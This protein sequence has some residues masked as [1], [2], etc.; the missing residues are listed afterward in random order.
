MLS[1]QDLGTVFIGW[2]GDTEHEYFYTF[3][4]ENTKLLHEKLIADG[5]QTKGLIEFLEEH[6]SWIDGC[7][8]LRDFCKK[9]KIR[10]Q[11]YVR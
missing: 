10:Y 5:K 2:F 1:G 6:F 11:F 4:I 9:K 3:N 8:N 7:K